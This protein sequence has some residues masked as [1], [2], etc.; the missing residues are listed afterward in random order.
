M[1]KNIIF[2]LGGV[3]LDIYYD[4]TEAEFRSLGWENFSESYS[5]AKQGGLFDEFECGILSA[6]RFFEQLMINAPEGITTEDL[7]IAWNAMLGEMP[8]YKMDFLEELGRK[9]RLVLF[10]NT[11]ETHINT[12]TGILRSQSL[13]ERFESVF[14]KIYYSSVLG[15]RKPNVSAFSKIINEL[16][17]RPEETLFIDDSPQHLIGAKN[18]GIKTIEA[19]SNSDIRALIISFLDKAQ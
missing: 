18:L 7:K 16:N 11:N 12:F 14:E 6:E 17:L 19:E 3:L 13:L 1:I 8:G 2:D 10:S 15:D 5:Q 4:R 9:Y